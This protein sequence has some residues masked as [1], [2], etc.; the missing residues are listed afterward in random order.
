MKKQTF[1][2]AIALLLLAACGSNDNGTKDG[3]SIEMANGE[4]IDNITIDI[5]AKSFS[6]IDEDN[7][8][9]IVDHGDNFLQAAYSDGKY[10]VE[11]KVNNMQYEAKKLLSKDS[12]LTLFTKYLNEDEDWNKAVVWELQ[13][14]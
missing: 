8:Y 11:Y 9:I 10:D 4:T 13:D 6:S 14:N 5:L 3:Y 1:I 7:N 2:M 12:T